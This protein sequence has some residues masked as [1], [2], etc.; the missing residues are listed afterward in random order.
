MTEGQN[1]PP[2]RS[3]DQKA[4]ANQFQNSNLSPRPKICLGRVLS[5]FTF[6]WLLQVCINELL[7]VEIRTSVH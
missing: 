7:S 2:H 5:H 3:D 1:P 6:I 4:S